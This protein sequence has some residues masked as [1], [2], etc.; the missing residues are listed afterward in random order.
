MLK[1]AALK[2]APKAIDSSPLIWD[3]T[4]TGSKKSFTNLVTKGILLA[5]PIISTDWISFLV[6]PAFSTANC[7]L[8]VIWLNKED[9]Y[10]TSLL[11]FMLKSRPLIKPSIKMLASL[12]AERVSFKS[13]HLWSSLTQDFSLVLTS[14]LCWDLNES[15]IYYASYLSISSPPILG[16]EICDSTLILSIFF[17]LIGSR[18]PKNWTIDICNMLLPRLKKPMLTGS[19]SLRVIAKWI[20]AAEF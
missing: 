6:R 10:I 2:A 8:A 9:L 1:L 11:M 16:T 12:F 13:A 14:I 4:S 20:A 7:K 18:V 5:P 15:A 19:E 3:P 17:Y